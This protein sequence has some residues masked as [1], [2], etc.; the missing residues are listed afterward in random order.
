MEALGGE[1]ATQEHFAQALEDALPVLE[2]GLKFYQSI[3]S[4]TAGEL[5]GVRDAARSDETRRQKARAAGRQGG[6]K[7]NRKRPAAAAERRWRI[8]EFAAFRPWMSANQ[9]ATAAYD[10]FKGT[11]WELSFHRIRAILTG[12]R[13]WKKRR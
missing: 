4:M 8:L 10:E 12:D 2:E 6:S 13:S 1:Y 7:P 3:N 11:P 5:L 9:R